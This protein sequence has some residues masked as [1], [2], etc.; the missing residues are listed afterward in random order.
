MTWLWWL[1]FGT[2]FA[3]FAAVTWA[4][5]ETQRPRKCNLD[6][7]SWVMW[8]V[9]HLGIALT[10]LMLMMQQ[11]ERDTVPPAHILVLKVCLA[12]RLVV[13]WNHRSTA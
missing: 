12:I 4:L 5:Y 11:L 1:N 9:V 10:M 13:P 8:S 7:A 3:V 6:R 2:S